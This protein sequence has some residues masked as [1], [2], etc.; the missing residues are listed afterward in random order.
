MNTTQAID[1]GKDIVKHV[2]SFVTPPL[3]RNKPIHDWPGWLGR[4]HGVKVPQAVSA[5]NDLSPT[6]AANINILTSLI[7]AT[8]HLDGDI[9]DCGVFRAASTVGM[10]LFLRERGI[11]KNI[12]GFDSFEGFDEETFQSDLSLGGVENEDRNRHGFRSTSLAI[13]E[14][15]VRRFRLDNIRFVPGY[16]NVSF[17]QFD[18]NVRFSFAHLDVNLYGSYKDC[19]Q[20]FYPRMVPGGVILLD[21]YN[22]PPWPGCN[23]A[24]DEFLADKPEQLQLI[25]MNNY[26]KYFITV[27]AEAVKTQAVWREKPESVAGSKAA[28]FA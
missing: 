7:E 1:V 21:E 28:I 6:G 23:R 19:M 18:A 9:A 25:S 24:V 22:D 15:K 14:R 8:R 17:P 12:Y 10:G 2:V 13:V 26:Q 5:K 11:R 4:V 3:L 16:F 27:G 20:F